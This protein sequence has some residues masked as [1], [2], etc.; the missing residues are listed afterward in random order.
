LSGISSSDQQLSQ[1]SIQNCAPEQAEGF[2]ILTGLTNL[3]LLQGVGWSSQGAG[4]KAFIK[5]EIPKFCF[6]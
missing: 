6:N 2:L 4:Q 5:E 1:N 3:G